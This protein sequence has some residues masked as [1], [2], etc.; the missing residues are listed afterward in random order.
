VNDFLNDLGI[1]SPALG[2][3]VGFLFGL[4]LAVIFSWVAS[5]ISRRR[6]AEEAG[7]RG[8]QAVVPDL[9]ETRWQH[10]LNEAT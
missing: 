4:L 3:T 5:S 8:V 9:H 6:A 10:V 7:G 2:L 1:A